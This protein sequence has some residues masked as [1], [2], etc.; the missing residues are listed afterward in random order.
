MYNKIKINRIQ[1]VHENSL[2]YRDIKP[3]NF[4]VGHIMYVFNLNIDYFLYN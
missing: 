2:V 4:L 3:D 1:T